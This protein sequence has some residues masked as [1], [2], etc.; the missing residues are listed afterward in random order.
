[1]VVARRA[2]LL[3]QAVV[4]E[5]SGVELRLLALVTARIKLGLALEVAVAVAVAVEVVEEVSI[6]SRHLSQVILT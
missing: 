6:Y 4:L 1:M 3:A 2:R 5:L